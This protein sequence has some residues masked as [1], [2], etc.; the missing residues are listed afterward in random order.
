MGILNATPDSFFDGG[1]F[2]N[3]EA[4]VKRGRQLHLEGADI[5]DIGGESSRPGAEAVSVQEELARTI[6]VIEALRAELPIPISIDTCKPQVAKAAIKAGANLINDI[7]GL[8]DPGMRKIAAETGMDVCIMHMRGD[9][10]TMQVDPHYTEGIISHIIYWFEQQIKEL[11][12]F[13]ISEDKI[14]LDPGI[15]FGKTVADN[16]EIIQ[17][18]PRFKALGFRVLVGISRKSFMSKILNKPASDLLAATLAVNT[19]LIRS[20][21]DIIRVHDVREHKDIIE[22]LKKLA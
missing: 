19:L 5:I 7:T 14:I 16:L 6:P 4:A 10:K 20:G 2:L 18:L 22:V 17:N 1:K 13:G 9:P 12:Q 11:I 15:G 3:L 8:Q 21:V